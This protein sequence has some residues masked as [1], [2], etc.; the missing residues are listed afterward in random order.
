M[1]EPRFGCGCY[2]WRDLIYVAGCGSNR[3]EVFNPETLEFT[4]I[5]V[6]IPLHGYELAMTGHG[7][8]LVIIGEKI[9]R[10]NLITEEIEQESP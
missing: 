3:V 9:L 8:N 7:E 1:A 10:I 6:V 4:T 5:S 2:V